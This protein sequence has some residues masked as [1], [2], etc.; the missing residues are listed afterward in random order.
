[1]SRRCLILGCSQLKSDERGLLPA[2]YRYEGPSYRVLHK[3]LRES[4]LL[5]ELLDVF[6]LSAEYGLIPGDKAII[7]YDHRMTASRAAELR[8]EVMAA[9][10]QSIIPP[11]YG[12]IFLSMG[13]DYL[14]A[15]KGFEKELAPETKLIISGGSAGRKL[16][17]LKAW[18][19]GE[20][21]VQERLGKAIP[22]LPKEDP[23]TVVLRGR[24]VSLTTE[25]ALARLQ[26]GM[27]E[28]PEAARS[29]NTWYLTIS[30]MKISP[31]W[32]AGYVFGV[33]V[34]EFAADEAR[35][36]LRRLG[37]NAYRR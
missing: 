36:A 28:E 33:P 4:P 2:I 9:V 10:R 26:K 1:M 5:A 30:G 21:A 13:Q 32:A 29:I 12:E 20:E 14:Q 15:I 24:T 34:C 22:V 16:T 25:Q 8:I 35:R 6:V 27:D 3:F 19:W 17:E 18:L 11:Q 23:Q 37:I 31:K 7:A